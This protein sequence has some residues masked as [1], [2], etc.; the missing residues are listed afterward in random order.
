MGRVPCCSLG[1]NGHAVND[2]GKVGSGITIYPYCLYWHFGKMDGY[3]AHPGYSRDFSQSN[4][5][6]PLGEVD[7]GYDKG[8][9]GENGRRRRSWN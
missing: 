6:Y 1:E 9:E 5:P 3:R 4:V 2:H 7:V 8:L